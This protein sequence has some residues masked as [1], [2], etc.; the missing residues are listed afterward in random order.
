[1]A[2]KQLNS[3]KSGSRCNSSSES[4][5]LHG[6]RGELGLPHTGGQELNDEAKSL[7]QNQSLSGS[8]RRSCPG[9]ALHP[10]RLKCS[11]HSVPTPR[12]PGQR[13][14]RAS[15]FPTSH[16]SARHPSPTPRA[17]PQ[18]RPGLPAGATLEVDPPSPFESAD[19]AA[20]LTHECDHERDV[21]HA[22]PGGDLPPLLTR[23]DHEDNRRLGCAATS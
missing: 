7:W 14:P 19:G 6:V 9:C 15:P 13:W 2:I 17:A 23:G 11:L 4:W 5:H 1:M 8:S 22:A 3:S 12:A 10:R 18:T 20:P 21:K 16:R